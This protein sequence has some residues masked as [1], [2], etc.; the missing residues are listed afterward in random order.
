MADEPT[1]EATLS[2]LLAQREQAE[3][4]KAIKRDLP[5]RIAC[6]FGEPMACNIALNIIKLVTESALSAPGATTEEKDQARKAYHA[7]RDALNELGR[8]RDAQVQ[9]TTRGGGT[10]G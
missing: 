10:D 3:L 5:K 8:V 2:T 7:A 9:R 6:Q 1:N 4:D